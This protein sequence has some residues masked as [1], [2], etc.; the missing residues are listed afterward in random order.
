MTESDQDVGASDIDPASPRSMRPPD[1]G[2]ERAC[3][4]ALLAMSKRSTKHYSQYP[5]PND[6]KPL[7]HV[8]GNWLSLVNLR[9]EPDGIVLSYEAQKRLLIAMSTCLSG[10][11]PVVLCEEQMCFGVRQ[12]AELLRSIR[13]GWKWIAKACCPRR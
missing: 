13:S 2:Q 3:Q 4:Q 7:K 10:K 11:R 8:L 1:V 12:T 9:A 5:E 6:H